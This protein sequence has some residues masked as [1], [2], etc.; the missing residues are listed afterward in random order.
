MM[1]GDCTE[2]FKGELRIGQM[3]VGP[4]NAGLEKVLISP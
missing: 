3:E 1:M 4:S 2:I